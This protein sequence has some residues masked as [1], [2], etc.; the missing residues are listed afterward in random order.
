MDAERGGSFGLA[1]EAQDSWTRCTLLLGLEEQGELRTRRCRD[2]ELGGVGE[3][4]AETGV[5]TAQGS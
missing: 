3:E 5:R 2:V 4:G 1:V